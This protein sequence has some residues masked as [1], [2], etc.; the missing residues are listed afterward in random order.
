LFYS[1]VPEYHLLKEIKN[2][3]HP[4]RVLGSTEVFGET[5]AIDS[6]FFRSD[7][8]DDVVKNP[9]HVVADKV[10]SVVAPIRVHYRVTI[11]TENFENFLDSHLF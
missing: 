1:F 5:W 10:N 11:L 2:K 8:G 6:I 4:I 7:A 3:K 9:S